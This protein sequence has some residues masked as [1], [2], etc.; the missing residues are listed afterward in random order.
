MN[1]HSLPVHVSLHHVC[2]LFTTSTS[3]ALIFFLPLQPL[4][5]IAVFFGFFCFFLIA[6][7]LMDVFFFVPTQLACTTCF[8]NRTGGRMMEKLH[9]AA[10][11]VIETTQR[12]KNSV[13]VST[14]LLIYV[15]LSL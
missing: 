9:S 1:I 2:M 6:F 13:Q 11:A 14:A 4:L 15:M 12:N 7:I 8:F 5:L 3:T 10:V